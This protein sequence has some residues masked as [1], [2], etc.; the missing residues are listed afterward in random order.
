MATPIGR[1][2]TSEEIDAT[3]ARVVEA[4]EAG[5]PE[6]LARALRP[7]ERAQASQ[8]DAAIA[9]TRIV[10][11]RLVSFELGLELLAGVEEAHG[12]DAKMIA[13]VGEALEGAR[14]LDDLNAAAPDHP[15][16]EATVERLRDAARAARGGD[17]ERDLLSGLAT[18]TRMLSRRHDGLALETYQRLVELEPERT[19][20]HYNLGLF[21]KTRG[22]FREG[23]AANRRAIA[24]AGHERVEAFEWNLGICATGAREA[25]VAL[26]VWK[27]MGQKIEMGRFDLPDGRYP[28]CKVKLAERPLAE[29]SAEAD[30]PGLEET[31]WIERLSPCH[32]IVR[33]VLVQALGVDYG[34]VVL[35]DGAPITH[36]RYG[37]DRIP[38]FPHLA[39][40]VR[41]AYR[42]YDF[43]GTQDEPRRL[44]D[45]SRE[46]E[47]DAVVYSHTESHRTLCKACWREG[48]SDHAHGADET[49]HVV[50]GR[51]A[52]PRGIAPAA[53]LAQLDRALAARSRCS[54]YAPSLCE[55]AGLSER[56][57][58][59]RRRF[60]LLRANV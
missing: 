35:I 30:D 41:S 1:V 27:R 57:A 9:L 6:G 22:R 48:E 58:I 47:D 13:L 19:A 16:F 53:L 36:H 17:G 24:L 28:H 60:E 46:L 25:A 7:L 56:A 14:D 50:T 26:D 23:L 3:V 20:A 42:F 52:A 49:R 39:T 44:A 43:A 18:A 31:I 37:D 38:V 51:I 8:R 11:R 33:S 2:L 29:R 55:A 10:E 5:D 12:A 4:S 21:Y 34:D 54:L 59:E 15:L 40:L 32:G 45:A